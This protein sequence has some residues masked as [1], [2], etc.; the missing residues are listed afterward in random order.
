MNQQQFQTFKK[1]LLPGDIILIGGGGF[2]ADVIREGQAIADPSWTSQLSHAAFVQADGQISESTLSWRWDKIPTFPWFKINISSG[3]QISDGASWNDGE[4]LKWICIVRLNGLTS[5][6]INAATARGQEL[7]A[8]KMFY[9]VRELVGDLISETNYRFLGMLKWINPPY[10]EKCMKDLL[11]KKNP[12]DAKNAMYCCCYVNDCYQTAGTR[13]LPTTMDESNSKVGD[14][15]KNK[16]TDYTLVFLEPS[17]LKPY[18]KTA[19]QDYS[20][21]LDFVK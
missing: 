6:T 18:S 2:I 7:L 10:F 12:L 21:N 4:V 13:L 8:Q 11:L 20:L 9:P 16:D 15:L 17:E 3:V 19:G 1:A 5:A 14:L